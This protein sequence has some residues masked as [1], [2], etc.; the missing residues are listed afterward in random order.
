MAKPA[1]SAATIQTA[2]PFHTDS[3][4]KCVFC[5]PASKK[6][7]NNFN[8]AVFYFLNGAHLYSLCICI[9]GNEGF[10]KVKDLSEQLRWSYLIMYREESLSRL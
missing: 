3:L 4:D 6:E 2:L 7:I 10:W 1:K 9:Y 5:T 8:V